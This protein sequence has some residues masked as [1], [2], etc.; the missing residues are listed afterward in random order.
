LHIS[1]Q[2]DAHFDCIDLLSDQDALMSVGYRALTPENSFRHRVARRISKLYFGALHGRR[3][4]AGI[5]LRS[6][7]RKSVVSKI[8]LWATRALSRP[9][10]GKHIFDET[11]RPYYGTVWF[12]A[13]RHVVSAMVKSF[14][15]PG[16]RDYF[17]RLCIA[18]EFLI[19][20]L[21][22]QLEPSKGPMNHYIKKFDQAHPGMFSEK[23]MEL[24]RKSPAYF[25]R[26]FPDDPSAPVRTRVL[27]DLAGTKAFP[28][29]A[30]KTSISQDCVPS[31]LTVNLMSALP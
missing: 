6:G 3:D 18:E 21:L 29:D 30:N 25:A 31:D 23:D 15:R 13:S 28:S 17:S 2:A 9:A 19:P 1:G 11:F 7:G 14:L 26:K 4:E 10:I 27:E 12:G 24:L 20:T 22:M 5:W 16:V 8:A